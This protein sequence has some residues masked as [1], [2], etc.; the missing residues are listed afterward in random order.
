M[1]KTLHF[2]LISIWNK[3]RYRFCSSIKFYYAFQLDQL[4]GFFFL[5]K[6][7]TLRQERECNN[8]LN[9]SDPFCA[10]TARGEDEKDDLIFRLVW[11]RD[12]HTEITTSLI[13]SLIQKILEPEG[14]KENAFDMFGEIEA[15]SKDLVHVH[16]NSKDT[17]V[18]IAGSKSIGPDIRK[19]FLFR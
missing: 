19:D 12:Q 7:T 10:K 1:D 6:N 5:L 18:P 15:I 3:T 8:I 4:I 16:T 2:Y 17:D 14:S 9:R 11:E 13:E